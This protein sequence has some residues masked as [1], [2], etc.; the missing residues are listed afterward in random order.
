MKNLLSSVKFVSEAMDLSFPVNSFPDHAR[1]A[2]ETST[3]SLPGA[4]NDTNNSQEDVQS[5]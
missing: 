5:P 1:P 2:K 3:S 4:T